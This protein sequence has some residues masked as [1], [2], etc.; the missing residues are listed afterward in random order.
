M[1][2][3]NL[4]SKGQGFFKRQVFSKNKNQW[5][6]QLRRKSMLL[7][8]GSVL[9]MA[10]SLAWS[11]EFSAS[12]K[13]T[14]IQEFIN[15][16]SKNLNKTV[17]IDPSVSGT[18][19]VRSYDMMNE[20]QYYQF[21]LSVLDVYGFTVIPMDN[22]VLKIIRSK[23]AKSTSMPLATDEQPG[24]G[25]EVVTRV[26]PVN[27]VAARD[28]APLLR[29]LNDNAGA[30]SVVHYE[31]SN[32]LL[33]TGRAGVIKRLM[34][35]VERVD[36]TGDRNVTSVPLS[37]ASSTEVVKM[38]NELNKMDEK[39]A[40]PGML[41]A[42]VVADERT[43]SVLVR[44]EP[45]SRQRVIDMIKQLD[46]Q[47]AVQGNTKV[48][49][50]K[51]AKATDLVEVLTGV[52]DSIQTD[53][54]NALPAL[55]KDIS[56]KAH[57]QTNSLIVNA[58][59]DIMRDL[60]QVIA[61]LDIRR[62][63]VLVEAIIA[64]VQDADGMNLGVQWA[65]KN[66]GVT[67]FTNTGLPIT[68]MMAG[69]DQFRRDGTLGTAAT[70]ALGS[71]N[72][73]AAG[74]YQGNWGMLMTALSS[75]SKNDILATPSIVTLD[76][77]E[78]TFNVGQEVPVLAGSQTTSGDNV[79]QTVE[80]K[81]VGIKLKVKPQINEGDSVL[82]EIEQEVS[83]VADSASSSSAELGATFNTRTVNNA[84]L[85]S[86]G[87]TVVVGGLLDKSTRESS[88]K[89]PLLGDIPILG[90]LFRSNSQETSKRNLMLFIRPSIIRDRSQYQSAS[91]SKYHSFNAEEEKQRNV[92]NGEG[93]LLD[94]DLL[95][96]P[97][98]GNAYTFRQVQSS[99]VAFYPA[100]GK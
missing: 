80:R 55:R 22:N 85:V 93:G 86:S 44:G 23:D 36:Q 47:Q 15:T 95:R 59:P 28:L 99:I 35:I 72:G 45:N 30:G 20:E 6:G 1:E 100:D 2:T 52:G 73:I 26:V 25:D 49:Y 74:F 77:M 17:I 65:N 91:A 68:T 78:A 41:T 34:T 7:L 39:S 79:F 12:F 64:E 66:A 10:S 54:Q 56:I 38:V 60:E 71:F 58:A 14:D 87:E 92:S 19:T 33:M 18:I 61:Q 9:L 96:L 97:E 37:Y 43:N 62:P 40:L 75:N 46:R 48:I 81:T 21:F 24:I 70:S 51:Y 89:V 98:G 5:L 84:V 27:N 8:S 3:T 63:Q 29:Q 53:Q 4:F 94:N 32:V 57:E 82:L 11:A 90:Y 88:S 83:S 13:G 76:N 16:V 67:Q 50:L 31:P 42:N 69:A